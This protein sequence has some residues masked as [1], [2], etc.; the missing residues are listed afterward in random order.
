M[1][2]G[3]DKKGVKEF[4]KSHSSWLPAQERG[5]GSGKVDDFIALMRKSRMAKQ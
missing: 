1:A 4:I 5:G 3:G 2:F